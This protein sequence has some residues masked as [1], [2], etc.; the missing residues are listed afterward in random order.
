MLSRAQLL[1]S[2]FY[3]SQFVLLG[4]QLPFF[5]GWL[6]LHGFTAP[7]IGWITGAALAARLLLGPFVAYW[8]DR[9]NDERLALRIVSA[10]FAAGAIGLWLEPGKLMIAFS[11]AAVLWTFGLL[12]P[13]SDSAA[14]RADRA[15][16]MNYG[17]AR[18]VGSFAFLLTTLLGGAF[19]SRYG[20]S[21]SVFIMAAA[22]IST[23]LFACLLPKID[24][25]RTPSNDW[26]EAP[27][28]LVSSSFLLMILASGLT[29]G[30]HA[31]YYAFSI[32]H[33]SE[34]GYGPD[35][36]GVLWAVGVIAEIFLLTRVRGLAKKFSPAMM[37]G[38]GGVGAAL[39]WTLTAM[40]PSVPILLAAQTLHALTFAAAYLGAIEFISRAVPERLV[41]TAM[42]LMSTTG[43]GALT[44]L[45]T[46]A[47]GY[48]FAAYGADAAYLLMAV[49]G[50]AAA[51]LA[52]LLAMQ[53]DTGEA[54]K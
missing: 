7:E 48:L 39:R 24:E 28:L 41:N 16:R 33:W 29:Q 54:L 18:A 40:E 15:G 43:V 26:R 32:L 22:G 38:A 13:L 1:F 23:F 3:S 27:K 30:S 46:I 21:W 47:A 20:L 6:V 36:I 53:G 14:L 52:W 42:T 25:R 35:L 50:L 11:A 49:M 51:G 17:Q 12:V 8:A 2:G 34:L 37:I 5:S 9:Q 10:A 19:L 31:V 44:G 4:V 45:A